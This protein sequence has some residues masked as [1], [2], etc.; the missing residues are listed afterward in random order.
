[1]PSAETSSE[2]LKPNRATRCLSES[3]SGILA[4]IGN[5]QLEPGSLFANRFEIASLAGSGGM[6]TVYRATDRHSGGT[7]ALKLVRAGSGSSD[8]AERFLREA[9]LLSEL[10]HPGI[11]AHI[12]H[13]QAPDGQRFLAMEWLQGQDLAARLMRGPLQVRQCLHLI[14]QVAD[15][16]SV[17]HERGII[18]RDLKPSNLFLMEGDLGLVKLLDFGIARRIAS[19]QAMTRTG[20]VVGT[21]EY[22]APEQA[23]G[24]RDLTPATDVFSLGCVLYECLSGQPPFVADHVAAVLVRI[25]FEDPLPIEE[26]WP[27]ISPSLAALLNRMLAKDP[28][29]RIENALA[30]RSELLALGELPEP[31]LAA[32][33][34]SPRRP[35]E[36]FASQEQNLFSIVLAAPPEEE[37]GLGAT[38]PGGG[39]QLAGVDRRALMQELAALGGSADLL[40]NGTLV[41]MAPSL[42]SAQDQ[43]TVAAR[44]ALLV[45]ERWAD[46]IVSMATGRGTVH[47]RTAVGEVVELA[48]RSLKQGS[49]SLGGKPMSGVLIDPLSARLLAEQFVQMPRHDGAILVGEEKEVDA[50]RLLL[51]K[52]TPCVGRDAELGILELQLRSCIEDSSARAILVTAP[53]G[54]GKSRLRHEF[55]RRVERRGEP[56][57]V[58]LG[59]GDLLSTGAAYRMVARAIRALCGVSGC[60]PLPEQR[61]QLQARLGQNL[62]DS[63]KPRVLPFLGEL[64]GVPFS[65]EDYPFFK[66]AKQTPKMLPEYVKRACLAW[67]T[68]ECQAA[69]LLVVLDDLHWGDELTVALFDQALRDLRD[70]PLCVLGL[71]RPELHTTF[72]S[73]WVGHKLQQIELKGLGKRACERLIQQSLG[74]QV[75]PETVACIVEQS[76]GNALYLEELIR[77]AA[78]GQFDEKPDTVIAMLQARIGHLP[79]DARRAVLG[80]S[81]FGQPFWQ[82]GV[83]TVLGLS[84]QSPV[85]ED[86]LRGLIAKELIEA[87][88]SSRIPGQK[89]FG[90]RHAL[91][92]DAAYG[93]LT[94]TDKELGHKLAAEFLEER[95]E[96]RSVLAILGHHYRQAGLFD[97]AV[98]HYV[99]AGDQAA[100]RFLLAEARLHYVASAETLD[101]LPRNPALLRL[102][103]DLLTKQVQS[104][105]GIDSPE[106]NFQKLAQAREILEG[107]QQ[108]GDFVSVDRLRIA[109]LDY[110]Q[111]RQFIFS[112]QA[113]L[114]LPCFQR[115]LPV[116]HEFQEPDLILGPSV[117]LGLALCV[118]GQ[119]KKAIAMLEPMVGPMERVFGKDLDMMRAHLYLAIFLGLAG[120]HDSAER[121]IEHVRP[122]TEEIQQ[123]LY[124]GW[125][126]LCV[127]T[128]FA[129][130]EK[131]H[132]GLQASERTR[133][134][135]EEAKEP[136]FRYIGWDLVAMAQSALGHHEAALKSRE[137]AIELRQSFDG[138]VAKETFEAVHSGIY[139]RAGRL[140]EAA[141]LAAKTAGNARRTGAK[142]ALSYA[143]RIWGSALAKL[144]GA[145]AEVDAHFRE[146][147]Q[148]ADAVGNLM[149]ALWTEL[150]WG[151][152][153]QERGDR[154]GMDA[155]FQQVRERMLDEMSE[156]SRKQMLQ[157]IHET[158]QKTVM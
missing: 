78:D 87:H 32:T 29:Q 102:R 72:P 88:G 45:K 60:E 70:L 86:C 92:C 47:G 19:S 79:A 148:T 75:A 134:L 147:L 119:V 71:A 11:V 74:K 33:L 67:L 122:W 129:Y 155:H 141:S 17:A 61:Q 40:A 73:M 117:S 7:V 66:E 9:Q 81:V 137:K 4:K 156:C 20:M 53:P 121:L 18:H 23:R 22:M 145:Q 154:A 151:Q 107:L 43:A 106:L 116:G 62:Q 49:Q 5:L 113:N 138:G 57:T 132:A 94:D 69:P 56:V 48:A 50:S 97:K 39:V 46:A 44:A 90:F 131:W 96:K 2:A 104:S 65:D 31:S 124:L 80:A 105:L 103:V 128:T 6:G 108:A 35:A 146:S 125:F 58:L 30:L 157:I 135:G 158:T 27:G 83:A 8:E 110:F 10:R 76:A 63:D 12:A 41:V 133:Q 82:G 28:A 68:A 93:L 59:R 36:N 34:A 123:P 13:G 77:A 100:R 64:C 25:L 111:G 112:G 42:G 26:L 142:Y 3:V 99:Q 54:V 84:E 85:L 37:L 55:L 51:G 98:E 95:A 89:E 16:L 15:A 127:G 149:E 52:P 140:E 139:F 109:R 118:Q 114:A 21:P 1:M 144:V 143:E 24:S 152:V 126:F 14:E 120:R 101:R 153:C 150:A 115:A 91:V 130:L 136:F 38:L